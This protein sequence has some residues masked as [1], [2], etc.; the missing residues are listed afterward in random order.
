M[1]VYMCDCVSY[2]FSSFLDFNVK[3]SYHIIFDILR[4]LHHIRHNNV[5]D[6]DTFD[7]III[8]IFFSIYFLVSRY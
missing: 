1:F 3:E 8:N 6:M 4:L 2:F 5:T 7:A